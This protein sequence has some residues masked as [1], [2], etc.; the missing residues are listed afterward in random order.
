MKGKEYYSKKKKENEKEI[1][2]KN[3]HFIV[4]KES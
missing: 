1:E 4:K 2:N 3:S